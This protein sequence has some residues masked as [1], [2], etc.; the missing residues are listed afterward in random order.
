MTAISGTHPDAMITTEIL[1]GYL[2]EG[3][4]LRAARVVVAREP[5]SGYGFTAIGS[6]GDRGSANDITRRGA[7]DA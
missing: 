3:E 6:E 5:Q 7:A 1:R 4:L 2:H